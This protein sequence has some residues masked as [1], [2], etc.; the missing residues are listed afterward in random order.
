[1]TG[2][3]AG[4][5]RAIAHELAGRGHGVALLARREERL[6]KLASELSS[7]HGVRAEPLPCDLADPTA[8]A[9]L[10][11]RLT[12]LGLAVEVLVNDAGLGTYGSFVD[13][14]HQ[15]QLEQVRVMSEAVV[16]L[17]RAFAP[18]MRDRRR[19][20]IVILSSS[21]AFVPMPGYATYRATRAFCVA[22]GDSLHSELRD[23]GVAVSTICPGGVRSEFFDANGAQPVPS[24]MPGFLWRTPEQVAEESVDALARNKRVLVPGRPMRAMMAGRR[25]VPR[26]LLAATLNGLAAR[27]ADGPSGQ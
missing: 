26:P 24:V 6:S 16:D 10:P 23:R 17:S 13:S 18:E 15:L 1:M 4:I 27:A 22:F 9:M 14:D 25:L 5:G 8:R 11:E 3:S 21:L 7:E 19:G 20:G 2:A 12:E